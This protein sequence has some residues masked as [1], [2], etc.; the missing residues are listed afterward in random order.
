MF[1]VP[2]CSRPSAMAQQAQDHEN[3]SSGIPVEQ[4]FAD[5]AALRTTH[6]P[7]IV[8]PFLQGGLRCFGWSATSSPPG[9]AGCLSGAVR[10]SRSAAGILAFVVLD[11]GSMDGPAE[12]INTPAREQREMM[13][14]INGRITR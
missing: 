12:A 11:R 1:V 4:R 14:N 6:Q 9:R 7:S 10:R 13:G 5:G 8:A 2:C 3:L